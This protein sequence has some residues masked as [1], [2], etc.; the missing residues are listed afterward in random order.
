MSSWGT[1]WGTSWGDSWGSGAP[2]I[3]PPVA[4]VRFGFFGSRSGYHR[5]R[6]EEEEEKRKAK[7]PIENSS[8]VRELLSRIYDAGIKPD[9]VAIVVGS[10]GG[11]EYVEVRIQS[12]SKRNLYAVIAII[13]ASEL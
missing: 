8:E 12:A 1:S 5:R 13:L 6:K 2:V 4:V 10:Q 7:G 9:K 3:P 11:E